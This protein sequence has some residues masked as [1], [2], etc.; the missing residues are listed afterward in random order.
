MVLFALASR[1]SSC[2]SRKGVW[3]IDNVAAHMALIRGRSDS[4]DFEPLAHLIHV[5]LFSLQTW[6]CW[7]WI[8]TKSN[9]SDSIS[10]LG[11]VD[12]WS[13]ANGFVLHPSSYPLEVWSLPLL[14]QVSAL[15]IRTEGGSWQYM[16]SRSCL[17]GQAVTSEPNVL[18]K[19]VL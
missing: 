18:P 19:H 10:R 9:W 11:E 5:A 17:L 16:A 4:P 12:P 3:F 8:P 6:V 15:G 14:F 13:A 7:E 2:R 1:A